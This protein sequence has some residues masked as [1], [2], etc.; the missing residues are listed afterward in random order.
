MWNISDGVGI[1]KGSYVPSFAKLLNIKFY[2][3]E[4]Y[5]QYIAQDKFKFI[6]LC[7]KLNI[8]TPKTILYSHEMN[9]FFPSNPIDF[10]SKDEILFIKPNSF[11]NNIGIRC[12][13]KTELKYL[14]CNIKEISNTL[15]SDTLIQEYIDGYDIRVCYVGKTEI[16][17]EKI[18][19]LKVEKFISDRKETIEF[20]NETEAD[21]VECEVTT[22]ENLDLHK[23]IVNDV[24]K[25]AKFL[26]L[27]NYF[28]FDVRVEKNN[29]NYYFLELNTAPFVI[30]KMMEKYAEL[31]YSKTIE[32]VFYESIIDAFLKDN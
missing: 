22:L 5:S 11:D 25:I 7:Q 23:K 3:S 32:E 31:Y 2:G 12:N 14:Q 4:T 21:E 20:I 19:C 29:E 1:Y 6:T 17:E 15:K 24:V 18:G 16:E 28:A 30:N 9:K 8:P 27:K 26:N 13:A 10:F